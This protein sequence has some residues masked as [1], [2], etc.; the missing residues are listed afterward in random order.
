MAYTVD[1]PLES[2]TMADIIIVLFTW[3]FPDGC[4]FVIVG[5]VFLYTSSYILTGQV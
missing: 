3:T 2:D 4:V 1:T 5:G